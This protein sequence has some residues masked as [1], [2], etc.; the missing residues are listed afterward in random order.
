MHLGSCLELQS[1][2]TKHCVPV[3]AAAPAMEGVCS[4]LRYALSDAHRPIETP[5]MRIL[6]LSPSYYPDAGGAETYLQQVS[7][8][9]AQRGHEITVFVTHA[10]ISSRFPAGN[11]LNLARSEVINRVAV[12]RFEPKG[13]FLRWL[14][15][16]LRQRGSYRFL[17]MFMPPEKIEMLSGG[18]LNLGTIAAALRYKAD[19]LTVTNWSFTSIVYQG[20][21]I[22]RLTNVPLLGIPLLH[23][24]E[25]WS[26]SALRAEMLAKCDVILALTDHEKRF[27][28]PR[29]PR[30]CGVHVVGA[31]VD[32]QSFS[33]RDGAQVRRRYG[34]GDAP[35]VGYVGRMQ[36][37]K[38][39]VT[40]IE[41]MKSVW[42]LDSRVRLLLAGRHFPRGTRQDQEFEQALAGL[43]PGERARVIHVDGFDDKEKPS[44]FD[45]MDVFAMPSTAESFGIAYLEAWMCR[46]P[47]IGSR[48]G[49][50]QCVVEDG[51]D[52]VLVDPND[53][54]EI[55]AVILELLADRKRAQRMGQQGY[56][57]TLSRFTW[58]KITDKVER[59]F[60]NLIATSDQ[61]RQSPSA[62]SPR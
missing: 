25:E 28:E 16:L 13:H 21:L 5:L 7:E 4:S 53:P 60:L 52:G 11:H 42:A 57:K 14:N 19:I 31:G 18:P 17:R 24:E 23:T 45:A 22:K 48:I 34:I 47:V 2:S 10:P 54:R 50:T 27:I 20:Y 62:P 49:S 39:V 58:D 61:G 38:G 30:Y 37:T 36:P 29:V 15:T 8:R 56:E 26:R 1:G 6:H 12:K 51:V 3:L 41:A 59:I 32:P 35:V 40:T 44:I 33:D 9:L 46:K 43:S 55:A